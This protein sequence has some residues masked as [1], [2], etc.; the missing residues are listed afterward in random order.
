[1]PHIL[2][3]ESITEQIAAAYSPTFKVPWMQ[4]LV[5]EL[6]QT[7]SGEAIETL[8]KDFKKNLLGLV[9]KGLNKLESPYISKGKFI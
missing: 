6:I 9:T 3:A 4:S 2:S 1:M 7:S 8:T 5:Y